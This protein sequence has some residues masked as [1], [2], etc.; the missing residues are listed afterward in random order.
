[1]PQRIREAREESLRSLQTRQGLS[2]N[3]T[4][5]TLCNS[6][7]RQGRYWSHPIYRLR[8]DLYRR[9]CLRLAHRWSPDRRR[10]LP[11][12][13]CRRLSFRMRLSD[14]CQHWHRY[15]REDPLLHRLP[16]MSSRPFRP[17][18]HRHLNRLHL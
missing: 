18:R 7:H 14:H 8:P 11:L 5:A 6:S 3:N 1:M 10:S 2:D 17:S 12:S 15:L 4:R 16:W 13:H 9:P